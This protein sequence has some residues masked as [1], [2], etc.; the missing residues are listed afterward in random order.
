[1]Q[2]LA[3]VFLCASVPL[4]LDLLYYFALLFVSSL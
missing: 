3:S 1:M 4:W 2:L